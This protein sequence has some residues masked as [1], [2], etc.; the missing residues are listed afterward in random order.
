[1]KASNS[2]QRSVGATTFA[3]H[4]LATA[5]ALALAGCGGGGGG[6]AA[7]TPAGPAAPP[8]PP[9]PAVVLS[10]VA[11]TG[12]ALT[13][14][15]VKIHSVGGDLVCS[16][17]TDSSGHYSCTLPS[18]AS[19]PFTVIAGTGE[20][21]LYSSAAAAAS[22]TVNVTP[23][24]TLVAALLA[25]SGDPARLVEALRSDPSVVTPAKIDAK[26]AEVAALIA[27]LTTAAGD[28][29]N[30]ISE[31]FAADGT[32]HDR[33]LDSLQVSIRPEGSDSNIQITLKV[34]PASDNA[35]PIEISF[36]SNE[37]AMPPSVTIRPDDLVEAGMAGR[38]AD[39]VARLQACLAVPLAQRI[40]DVPA[41]ATTVTGDAASVKAPECRT[42]FVDSD[43]AKY[44]DNGLVVAS[45]SAFTTLFGDK[46]TAATFDR[47]N[48]EYKWAN[49]DI[50][51]SYR[52]TSTAGA[53]GYQALTLRNQGG[54]LKAIGNQYAYD[55]VVR[56]YVADREY[57]LQ[58]AYS[59]FAAGYSAA[60]ANRIDPATGN[61]MFK[62]AVVTTPNGSRLVYKP[63][64]G[65]SNLGLVRGD[66][67]TAGTTVEVFAAA[68][69]ES[70]T[71]GN[72]ADKD[73]FPVFSSTQRSDEELRAIPDQGVWTVE[74]TH[75]DP[76]L[77][78]I[79]QSYRTISRAPTLGE[80]R[81]AKF[82][83]VSAELK[84][85]W[86]ARDDVKAYNG[87]VFGAP[88]VEAPNTFAVE[89]ASG[90][91][92][93][94]V[95]DGAMAPTTVAIYG[96][97][98]GVSSFNNTR[99]VATTARKARIDCSSQSLADV[100]C[101]SSLV[102][103]FAAGGNVVQLELYGAS[104]RLVTVSKLLNL[105]RIAD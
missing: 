18:G 95:P 70:G 84:A 44:K 85:Q 81:L 98:P 26:V 12:A 100:H 101:D 11:A 60:I 102:N 47:G 27:P 42:L 88:S 19:A 36:K 72:P 48:F 62:Q 64:A 39:F 86:L 3:L 8:A 78:N 7:D 38:V 28:K 59:Y 45:N 76:A 79:K 89:T 55:A 15:P 57:P 30:P 92:G 52:A 51:V 40:A 77:P 34:K 90:G 69:K 71:A 37:A 63:L 80:A 103:Q 74:W 50:Y 46:W 5:V 17:T 13:A 56:P 33:V 83:Q 35:A 4:A 91:D 87:L 54:K 49:G 10:G 22:A 94:T 82:T 96:S 25:P 75:V 61:P 97:A 20:R 29:A 104:P 73:K 31:I 93:W 53:V 43:P 14:A 16:T 6:G 68:Y 32:G 67:S 24:T 21:T 58:P 9:P 99:A 2:A 1:M 41:G 105:Y 65:R 66:G 23:L